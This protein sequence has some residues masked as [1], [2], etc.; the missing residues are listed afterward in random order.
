VAWWVVG[1]PLTARG[2][3]TIGVN[4]IGSTVPQEFFEGRLLDCRPLAVETEWNPGPMRAV[5]LL[6]ACEPQA[7][8]APVLASGVSGRADIL[9]LQWRPNG[10]A[11]L[12]YDHWG[13][14]SATSPEFPW[15]AD[16]AH[17]LEVETPAL[18]VL[19]RV[20]AGSEGRGRL[21]VWV[22]GELA[23]ETEVA[24]H[25]PGVDTVRIG[26]NDVGASTASVRWP[27][28]V[29]DVTQVAFD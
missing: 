20:P 4:E 13:F 18:G 8:P 1:P 14:A 15:R 6:L 25:S 7:V 29:L 19:D 22:D 5:S 26:G 27:G 28:V 11:R 17:R 9:A 16:R 12:V 3:V 21:R 2:P 23:W 10:R 24:F